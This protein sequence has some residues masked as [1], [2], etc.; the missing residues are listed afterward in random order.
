M[1]P[2]VPTVLTVLALAACALAPT[3]G[4]AQLPDV[5]VRGLL[6]LVAAQRSDT[7]EL[8][9]LSRGDSPYDPYG[10]R[11][12]V[13]GNVNEHVDFFG[14]VVL[15]DGAT[16]YVD[17]AYVLFTPFHAYDTHLMAGKIP[18]PIGT[19]GPRTYSNKNP[20][21]ATPLMYQYH[22]TLLWYAL[23][24]SAD[25]LIAN[26]GNGQYGVDYFG[27]PMSKGMAVVD[28]SWWDV[29][30]SAVGSTGPV[31]CSMG[32]TAGTPGWG[33][34]VKDENS[35]KTIMGRIGLAPTPGLRFGVS[36]ALGP[37]LVEGLNG[38]LGPGQTVDGFYQTLGMVDAEFATGYFELRGEG[39][40]NTW[41]T[42]T[43]GDLGVTTGYVEMKYHL[44]FGAYAAGRLD[45]M[46]F[47]KIEDS[48][49]VEH[50]WDSNI[51]RWELGAGYRV[52]RNILMKL[53][54]QHTTMEGR[55]I[56][57]SLFAAQGSF[58]F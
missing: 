45:G 49:G 50:P 10:L 37:Y 38:E 55:D 44:P 43:V 57:P 29:G 8:N 25:V 16:P 54:Y 22:T 18:W 42:P 28:D 1:T 58:T 26:S 41:Q 14:Q 51:A 4:R 47:S 34:T 27:Y 32:I 15:R 12:F 30:I 35:G 39:A 53:V 11:L 9:T 48:G 3:P 31:E 17:G 33:S 21:I 23:P 13:D 52:D 56:K 46:R 19:Y 20:L 6:D 24:P 2:R 5:H 7:H 36:G 40:W